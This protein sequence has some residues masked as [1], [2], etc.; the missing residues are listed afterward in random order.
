MKITK[1]N[2]IMIAICFLLFGA[3]IIYPLRRAEANFGEV[4]YGVHLTSMNNTYA[5]NNVPFAFEQ[6]DFGTPGLWSASDPTKITI[7][8]SCVYLVGVDIT[9]LGIN[10]PGGVD[11]SKIVIQVLKNHPAN[12]PITEQ[13][14]NTIT[15]ETFFN[16]NAYGA[17]ANSYSTIVNLSVGDYLQVIIWSK[18]GRVLVESNPSNTNT[19]AGTGKISPHFYA[20]CLGA[21]PTP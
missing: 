17:R 20:H 19:G 16:E 8:Q 7:N 12:A 18:T 5:Y 15:G 9:T 11:N 2:R 14:Y 6:Q 21:L 10:Y 13:L 3:C 1:K 4:F